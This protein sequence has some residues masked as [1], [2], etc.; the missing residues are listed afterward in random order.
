MTNPTK[1]AISLVIP[2]FNKEVYMRGCLESILAQSFTDFEI[3]LVDDASS[4]SS[5]SIC[6]WYAQNHKSIVYLQHTKN[7]G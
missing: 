3:I 4:D 2:S 1:P 5:P 7:E 6:Q